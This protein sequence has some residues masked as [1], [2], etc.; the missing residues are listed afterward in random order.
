MKNKTKILQR[1]YDEKHITFEELEILMKET[2]PF[3]IQK[4][5]VKVDQITPW[6]QPYKYAPLQPY[7]TDWKI[8]CTNED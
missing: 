4:E 6:T 8:T 1:L 3:I 7:W 2:Q 5:I